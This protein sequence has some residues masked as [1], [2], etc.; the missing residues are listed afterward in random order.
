MHERAALSM[1]LL[2]QLLQYSAIC[3]YP[4]LQPENMFLDTL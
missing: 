1:P 4:L 2:R 3:V